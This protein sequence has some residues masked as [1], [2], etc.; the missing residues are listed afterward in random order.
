MKQ[1]GLI[2]LFTS[3][4]FFPET[5]YMLIYIIYSL[6]PDWAWLSAKKSI[7]VRQKA[8]HG[9]EWAFIMAIPLWL[10]WPEATIYGIAGYLLHLAIDYNG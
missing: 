9:I 1:H 5:G 7:G 4:L 2:A 3:L 8:F 10:V 6:L